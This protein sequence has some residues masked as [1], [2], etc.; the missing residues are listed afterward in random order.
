[1]RVL[2]SKYNYSHEG[3]IAYSSDQE[4]GSVDNE[5]INWFKRQKSTNM[6]IAF[7]I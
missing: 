1:M 6:R 5:L 4:C 7:F 3:E 2:Y